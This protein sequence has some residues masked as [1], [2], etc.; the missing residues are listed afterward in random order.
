MVKER[1]ISFEFFFQKDFFLPKSI[2]ILFKIKIQ[3]QNLI[4][5]III[6]ST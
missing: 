5:I 3:I 2:S 1:K 4:I 6:T